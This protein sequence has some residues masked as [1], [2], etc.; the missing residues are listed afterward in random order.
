MV[1]DAEGVGT[2]REHAGPLATEPGGPKGGEAARGRAA[3]RVAEP[4]PVPSAPRPR[5]RW[6]ITAWVVAALAIAFVM[7]LVRRAG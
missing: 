7:A 6:V 3:D 4:G 2:S 1:S 5:F